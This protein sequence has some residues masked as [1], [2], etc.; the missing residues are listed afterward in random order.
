VLNSQWNWESPIP[1]PEDGLEY[2]WSEEDLNWI[3]IINE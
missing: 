2:Q 3:E 1:Y